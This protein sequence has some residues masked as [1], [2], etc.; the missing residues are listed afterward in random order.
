MA[1]VVDASVALA[2]VLTDES[3]PV[4]RALLDRALGDGA[5]APALWPLEITNALLT[6]ERRKRISSRE[7]RVFLDRLALM[8]VSVESMPAAGEMQ[9]LADIAHGRG[10]S[11]Y[12]A[13]YLH[14]AQSRSM[15]LATLDRRLR[16]AAARASIAVLP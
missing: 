13:C 14:L 10:L 1:F 16:Q 11:V 8:P 3:T 12:D 6:A 9:T 2:W 5:S 15:P 4:A 7:R